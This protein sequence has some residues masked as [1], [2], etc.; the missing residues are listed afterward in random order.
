MPSTQYKPSAEDR[1]AIE[2]VVQAVV[3]CE[4]DWHTE[5]CRK[6]E[7]R[8]AAYR[9]LK[10]EA[11]NREVPKGWES[12][13]TQPFL[14]NIVEGFIASL[15]ENQPMWRVSPIP[16]PGQSAEQIQGR[17]INAEMAQ[18]RLQHDMNVDGFALKQGE[19]IEQDLIAGY[20]VGKTY[21]LRQ[22]KDIRY[23]VPGYDIVWDE[24]AGAIDIVDKYENKVDEGVVVRDGPTFEV[25]DVR[26]L[27]FPGSAKDPESAPFMVDRAWKTI[28]AL[29]AMEALGVY[30]NTEFVTTTNAD[31][32]DTVKDREQ[33]LRNVNRTK[34]L[35]EVLEYWDGNDVITIANRAILLRKRPNTQYG[36]GKYPFVFVSA[37][38]EM[39]QIPGISVV[40]GLAQMQD[41][42]WTLQ[43]T[44]LNALR[45]MAHPIT[46]IR[47][48]VNNADDFEWA[49]LAQW[50][51]EDP[52]SVKMME[53]DPTTANITIQAEALL[54]GDIAQIMGGSPFASGSQASTID[55]QTAT[56]ISIF[57]NV[58]QQLLARRR[59][60]YLWAYEKVACQFLSIAQE[61]VE[62]VQAVPV[63]E[64]GH[65]R[66][67]D[68]P[69]MGIQGFFDVKLE[70]ASESMIR[71]EE[72][73]EWQA[74]LTMALQ[75]A[76]P[77]MQMGV[78]LNI[79]KFWEGLL[80]S[81]DIID[82][83]A[84]VQEMPPPQMGPG[85]QVAGMGSPPAPGGNGS[86]PG[87][88]IAAL[89]G[90]AVG[91]DSSAEQQMAA[92]SGGGL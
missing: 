36:H 44:R 22:K 68:V 58:A 24:E 15:V 50:I 72:R 9:G 34:G 29:V 86:G 90:G 43:N 32:G 12:N 87:S 17:V 13:V 20:T 91:G 45:M 64:G 31:I 2:M 21:R 18:Y 71:K 3:S 57:A 88:E 53:I 33:R 7:R 16:I 47:S 11:E 77:S 76:A 40:E 59:Q 48:D 83:D 1:A 75:G 61:S 19:L 55:N 70:M 67:I 38:P 62:E 60:Q 73:A 39:F 46:L 78:K 14:I 84:Y 69:P 65:T 63:T 51:V 54:K 42:V 37:I 56:G 79:E 52:N 27:F 6:V 30:Q 81:F 23:R 92:R 74:L 66:Y 41:M 26:D 4:S 10:Q 5:F 28:D 25:R 8:Y 49:P 85:P 82:H 89:L 35:V 80:K